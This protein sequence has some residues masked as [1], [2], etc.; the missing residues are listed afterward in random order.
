M[1]DTPI[2]AKA[3]EIRCS[4]PE[5]S[6]LLDMTSGHFRPGTGDNSYSSNYQHYRNSQ[7]NLSNYLSYNDKKPRTRSSYP[8]QY[9]T[10]YYAYKNGG[11]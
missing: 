3:S 4:S 5:I 1:S 9:A 8:S 6:R 11:C 7:F 10:A 2:Y